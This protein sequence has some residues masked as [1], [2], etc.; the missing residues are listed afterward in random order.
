MRFFQ[1]DMILI[2]I[3]IFYE[4]ILYDVNILAKN[5]MR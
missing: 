3:N 5:E 1:S 4:T 2:E